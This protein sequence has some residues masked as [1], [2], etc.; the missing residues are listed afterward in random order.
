MRIQKNSKIPSENDE[1]TFTGKTLGQGSFAIVYEAESKKMKKKV[2][3]KV[4]T[5]KNLSSKDREQLEAEIG[6]M[7]QT[8]HPNILKLFESF[9]YSKRHFLIFEK[10][11]VDLLEEILRQEKKQLT[12]RMTRFL[13]FQICTGVE[14]LHS[15]NIA[16]CDLK[17]ENILLDQD[18]TLTSTPLVKLADFNYARKMSKQT[19]RTSIK[20]TLNYMA[21]ELLGRK[22]HTRSIDIW[23]LGVI[24]YVSLTGKF[25]FMGYDEEKMKSNVKLLLE[26]PD[27]LY[28]NERFQKGT[29]L[30]L[31]KSILIDDI[32]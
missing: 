25:P 1:Y 13:M 18:I 21:P 12:P 32:Q 28:K 8:N 29:T 19:R 9:E 20:G 3:I 7:E 5:R 30:D 27:I 17:P 24:L 22:Q 15:K 16:H 10:L 23:S 6:F 2:A 11:K 31:L 4:T 26:N 14:Y